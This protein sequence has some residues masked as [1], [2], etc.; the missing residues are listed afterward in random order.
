MANDIFSG[1]AAGYK[2]EIFSVKKVFYFSVD[3]A[4][5]T[6][7]LGPEGC[8]VEEGKTV[9]EADCVCKTSA[10]FL[11]RIWTGGYRPSAMDFMAGKIKS[12]APQE[13]QRFLAAF[14]K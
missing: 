9:E 2:K 8:L 4:R 3:E 7:T 11:D 1:L 6:V 13:L 12:N 14:G 5:W 10:D